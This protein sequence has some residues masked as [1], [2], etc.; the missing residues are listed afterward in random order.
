MISYL[1]RKWVNFSNSWWLNFKYF[2]KNF[3]RFLKELFS[4][5]HN[6]FPYAAVY[7]HNSWFV[8]TTKMQLQEYLKHHWGYPG[9]DEASAN[10]DWENIIKHM[11]DLLDYI[12]ENE[13]DYNTP[14][15]SDYIEEMRVKAKDEFFDL[16]SKWFFDLWD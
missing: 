9:R 10:E 7:D 16:Y 6:G 8:K 15:Q 2:P 14:F 4:F 11:I 1:W 3:C 13:F 12:E 5:I